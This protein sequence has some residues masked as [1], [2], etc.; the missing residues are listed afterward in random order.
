MA[1]RYL[2]AVK[3]TIDAFL[4]VRGTSF[5]GGLVFRQFVEFMPL[6]EHPSSRMPLTKEYRLFFLHGV[7]IARLRYWDIEGYTETDMPPSDLFVDIAKQ[8]RSNFFTM[9]IAQRTDGE[10]M[11]IELG[12]A[13]V[14]GLPKNAD[15]DAFYRALS[16]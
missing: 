15:V 10:W 8:V 2:K 5:E 14:A 7:L 16:Q 9:D 4:E 6:T 12:D 11:I 13:Q 3:N 1:R